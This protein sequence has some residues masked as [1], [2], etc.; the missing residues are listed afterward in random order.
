M[1]VLAEVLVVLL[2]NA[3]VVHVFQLVPLS[4]D[5]IIGVLWSFT[6]LLGSCVHS[7]KVFYIGTEG[8]SVRLEIDCVQLEELFYQPT[9]ATWW[10]Y[11]IKSYKEF[12]DSSPQQ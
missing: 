6:P 10:T 5:C 2:F 1:L 4:N 9:I 12:L 11:T 7:Q 3:K 8:V